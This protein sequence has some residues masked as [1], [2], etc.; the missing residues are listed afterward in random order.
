MSDVG[1]RR[2]LPAL[3]AQDGDLP[4]LLAPPRAR[5]ER[6]APLHVGWSTYAS[7]LEVRGLAVSVRPC[8]CR[9][10]RWRSFSVL[11]RTFLLAGLWP[12][13]AR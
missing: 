5:E 13:G 12:A 10:H 2:D 7:Q 6:V 8:R 11:K 3:R 1:E 9:G 4:A